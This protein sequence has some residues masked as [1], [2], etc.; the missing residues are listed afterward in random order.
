VIELELP[1]P[2]SVNRTRKIDWRE[3]KKADEWQRRADA[4]FLT[5]KRGLAGKAI[6]GRFEASIVLGEDCRL[7]LDNAAKA[8]I[9][10]AKRFGLVVDDG[11][12]YMRRVTLEFGE[13][14]KGSCR[15]ILR[16]WDSGDNG[17]TPRG[18]MDGT[19]PLA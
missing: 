15:L 12:K 19:P 9:D 7:D 6:Q 1:A 8:L 14:P 11:P 18:G 17:T 4:L 5:Q 10:M 3:K 13:V 2:L 16:P